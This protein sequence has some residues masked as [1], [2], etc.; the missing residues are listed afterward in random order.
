VGKRASVMGCFFLLSGGITFFT[1][2]T[3]SSGW[4]L[5]VMTVMMMM[6]DLFSLLPFFLF[7]FTDSF[8]TV[9]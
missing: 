9:V 6:K 7:S 8:L 2:L 1:F 3:F 5:Y 4:I